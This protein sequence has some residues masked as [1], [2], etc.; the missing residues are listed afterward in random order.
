MTV[1]GRMFLGEGMPCKG[2]NECIIGM[3]KMG[4]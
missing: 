4:K 3:K 2:H 1:L